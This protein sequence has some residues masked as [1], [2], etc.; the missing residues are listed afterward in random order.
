MF[1]FMDNAKLH[2]I[3]FNDYHHW[4]WSLLQWESSSM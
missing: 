2:D 1:Q 4:Q 3:T